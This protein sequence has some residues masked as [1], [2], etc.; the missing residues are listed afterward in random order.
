MISSIFGQLDAVKSISDVSKT[1]GLHA[2]YAM[3]VHANQ[4]KR[5][6]A[7]F[8]LIKISQKYKKLGF[9]QKV[10][11]MAL[12]QTVLG[13]TQTLNLQNDKGDTLDCALFIEAS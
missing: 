13:Q 7:V 6:L 2:V 3:F 4:D 1:F 8:E 10:Q 9:I 11:F 5:F 12:E